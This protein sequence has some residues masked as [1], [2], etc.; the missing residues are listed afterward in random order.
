MRMLHTV[1]HGLHGGPCNVKPKV[2]LEQ[3]RA[4]SQ[5]RAKSKLHSQSHADAGAAT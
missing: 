2:T 5:V 1:A 4:N 3:F